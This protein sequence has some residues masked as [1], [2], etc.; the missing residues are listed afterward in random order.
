MTRSESAPS[1]EEYVVARGSDLVR[2][3]WFLTGDAAAADDLVVDT[4]GRAAR[5]WHG[6]T[7]DG[8]GA[9]DTTLTRRLLRTFLHGHDPARDP[10]SDRV[11]DGAGDPAGISGGQ[12]RAAGG[13]WAAL[14]GL[15]RH[16]RAVLV[17]RH[18]L[19]QPPERVAVLLDT[20]TATV[21]SRERAALDAFG[22]SES[23]A[24]AVLPAL[25]PSDPSTHGLASRARDRVDGR[26]RARTVASSAV[27]ALVVVAAA[28]VA[29]TSS[30]P[31]VQPAP[32]PTTTTRVALSCRTTTAEASVPDEAIWVLSDT[33]TAVLLCARRDDDSV[34]PGSLPPDDELTDPRAIDLVTIEPR[35]S[36]VECAGLVAGPTY[37]LLVRDRDGA[38]RSYENE[39]LACNGW[40]LLSSYY[41]AVA[42]QR[43][44]ED[45]AAAGFLGC[46]ALLGEH[47]RAAESSPKPLLAKG[48]VFTL[49]T[50]CLHQLPRDDVVP[51]FREVR[52]NVL[53]TPQLAQ[54]N[55]DARHAGSA[56]GSLPS[57]PMAG[58]L[59]VVRALTDSNRL[60]ELSGACGD[61]LSVNW[62][63]KDVWAVSAQTSSM[64]QALL[65]G[66]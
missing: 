47:P 8:G 43:A 29:A 58:S 51:R 25:V 9:I 34:W 40:P 36:G 1:L 57:C 28:V 13:A 64:L 52:S 44:A 5:D 15:P 19:D 45:Q 38:V 2:L 53:G 20:S 54:L 46:P 60:V 14:L 16:Q 27:A 31:K 37:R 23:G 63:P 3:A 17:L 39:V 48:T 35:T 33:A 49:A 56:L 11:I 6:L 62:S 65:S 10:A 59:V 4:L 50:A 22:R 66:R 7:D 26:R 12:P 42:E 30:P 32:G 61:V 41:V 55:A 21:A 18:A 24:R